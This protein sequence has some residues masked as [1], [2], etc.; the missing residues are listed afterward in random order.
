MQNV[1]RDLNFA[2]AAVVAVDADDDAD[3]DPLTPTGKRHL[4]QFETLKCYRLSYRSFRAFSRWLVLW[5]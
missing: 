2:A 1:T 3:E 4:K 5:W